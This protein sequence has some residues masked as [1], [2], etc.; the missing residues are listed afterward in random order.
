MLSTL[1]GTCNDTRR[2]WPPHGY[3]KEVGNSDLTLDVY[4]GMV[5]L[6]FLVL[7]ENRMDTSTPKQRVPHPF[8]RDPGTTRLDEPP[9]TCLDE[10]PFGRLVNF[11]TRVTGLTFCRA[12]GVQQ[13]GFKSSKTKSNHQRLKE[14]QKNLQ[15]WDVPC[16]VYIPEINWMMMIAC[17][18]ITVTFKTSDNLVAV[19]CRELLKSQLGPQLRPRGGQF[20]S[21]GQAKGMIKPKCGGG[22]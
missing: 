17:C 20:L 16:E 14:G 11:N 12:F 7:K 15:G 2:P 1:R 8:F 3:Q 18:V 6:R 21:M 10:S 22:F 13:P 4:P 19:A 5:L 9:C